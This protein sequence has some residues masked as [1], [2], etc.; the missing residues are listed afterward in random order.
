M[1]RI[2]I[3]RQAYN[4]GRFTRAVIVDMVVDLHPGGRTA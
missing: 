1:Q 4:Q 3:F 2:Y